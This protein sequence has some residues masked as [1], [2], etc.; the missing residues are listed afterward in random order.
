MTQVK[1]DPYDIPSDYPGCL[2]CGHF[3]AARCI[4]FP[5]AIPLIILDGQMH[6]LAPVTGQVGDTVFTPLDLEVWQKTRK[7]VPMRTPETT[8]AR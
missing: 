7:R 6:H 4:A 8:Q 5:K 3:R 1:C 2:G